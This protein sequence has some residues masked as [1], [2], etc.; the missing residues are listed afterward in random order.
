MNYTFDVLLLADGSENFRN[1]SLKIL[2]LCPSLY[3]SAPI[4][5]CDVILCVISKKIELGLTTCMYFFFGKI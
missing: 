4:L 3:L 2:R 1:S 5:S